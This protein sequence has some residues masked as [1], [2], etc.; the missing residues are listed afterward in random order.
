MAIPKHV[1][2]E[3]LQNLGSE[4]FEVF[5]WYLKEGLEGFPA[6][7]VCRLEDASR[8]T[9]VDEMVQT[10]VTDAV[11]MASTVLVRMKKYGLV[12]KLSKNTTAG[13]SFMRGEGLDFSWTSYGL[14]GTCSCRYRSICSRNVDGTS[15]FSHHINLLKWV[16]L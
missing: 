13:K 5:K 16:W 15:A 8:C 11:N 6:I 9:T 7:P 2:L 3:T 1:L 14:T 10:Y 12:K 4:D